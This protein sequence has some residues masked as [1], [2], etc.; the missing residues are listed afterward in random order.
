MGASVIAYWPGITA[1]QIE[2][3]GEGL[4][5]GG[6]LREEVIKEANE[7]K[8]RETEANRGTSATAC[9]AGRCSR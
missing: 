3:L 7:C 9:H 4:D 6:D 1:E 2:L 8:C 5:I